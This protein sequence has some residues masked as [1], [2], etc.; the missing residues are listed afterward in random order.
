MKG[1]LVHQWLEGQ[2]AERPDSLLV[3]EDGRDTSYGEVDHYANATAR[4]LRDQG[5]REGD[6][7]GLLAVN[8]AEYVYSY[9]GI[10]K[11]GAVVV[12][13]NASA[14]SDGY[15]HALRHCDA[16]GLIRGRRM[17]RR[18][19]G[20]EQVETLEFVLGWADDWADRNE[21]GG[22][23]RF[24]DQAVLSAMDCQAPDVALMPQ[25]R[26]AILYTPGSTGKPKGVTLTHKNIVANVN[27]I[28]QYLQ[29]TASDRVMVVLPFHYVYGKSLLNTHVAVGGSIVIENRF[30]YPGKALD[31]LEQTECTG[32]SGVPSTFAI[33][34]NKSNF[35]ER[36]FPHLR[37]VTQAGGAM[38]PR[39]QAR[40]IEALPGK[41]IF[42]MY[43]ATEASARLSYLPPHELSRKIGSIGKA[44][45]GV[46][47]R[48]LRDDHSPADVDEIGEL[49]AQGDNIMEG[50]WDAAEETAGV[51]DAHGYHTGDLAVRDEEGFLYVVGRKREMIKSG[52]HRI[53]PKE[54]EDVLQEHPAVHEAA[55]IGVPDEVLGETAAAFVSFC[56]EQITTTQE[57]ME[58]CRGRLPRYK[59]P[60]L[61]RFVDDFERN[62]SGKIDKLALG[63]KVEEICVEQ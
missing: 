3:K 33:L 58:W 13:L 27:S 39:M 15:R 32:F 41:D 57:I 62:A 28:V 59:L 38:A 2:A 20:V 61:M 31:T 55:V 45:P 26:A 52:A 44:I 51:L 46:K 14:N 9:Y 37:Y 1:K 11:A 19:A 29:L 63:E 16:K 8:S 18:A 36:E 60:G 42:I 40:L 48:V 30:L 6:R 4:L 17:G 5:I 56:S 7:V 22:Y 10:L 43:G 54:I 25:D 53:A 49:V 12:P 35:G 47:L 23:C 50:Y 34:L 24:V 21:L